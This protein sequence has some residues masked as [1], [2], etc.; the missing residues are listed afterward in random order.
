MGHIEKSIYNLMQ[1]EGLFLIIAKNRNWELLVETAHTEFQQYLA[2]I[3][4]IHG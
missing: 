2:T 3:S 4:A 1:Q